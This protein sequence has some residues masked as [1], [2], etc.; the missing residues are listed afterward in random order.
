MKQLIVFCALLLSSL[1]PV[2]AAAQ[3]LPNTAFWVGYNEAWFKDENYGNWL[4][5]NRVFNLG[6]KFAIGPN[7]FI[8]KMFAG[9]ANANSKAK[10]VRIWLFPALQGIRSPAPPLTPRTN[11]LT[12]E[13]VANLGKV[14]SLAQ[15]KGLK[16]YI[17]ALNGG[18]M[19]VTSD[20]PP[21]RRYFE[22]LLLN[23]NE[24]MTRYK[25]NALLPVLQKLNEFRDQ[26]V[27]YG[28]DLM[29]EIEAPLLAGYF[30]DGWVGARRWMADIAGFVH[31][32]SPW[33]PVTSSAGYGWEVSEITLGL[34]SGVGLNF[35]DA[36]VY[37]DTGDYAGQTGLCNRVRSDGAQI[38]LG[39]FGQ[40]SQIVNDDLQYW[41][42]ANFLYRAKTTCFTAALAWK[43]ETTMQPWLSYLKSDGTCCRPAF[44]I[45]QAYGTSP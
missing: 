25:I 32:V 6:S 18:D 23:R 31:Y 5:S 43:Y 26:N 9:M 10:I 39:E 35:Y 11:G 30:P 27:I 12:P 36:H 37:D 4:A 16:V 17:T 45:M 40:E 29:N 2:E 14:I 1:V 28:F 13:F 38:I 44:S 34:F 42:A 19:K 33:L 15:S 21:F 24:E 8:Q 22:N 41:S 20:Q 3:R 7:S